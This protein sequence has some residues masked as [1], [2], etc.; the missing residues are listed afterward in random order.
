MAARAGASKATIYRRW[1]SKEELAVELVRELGTRLAVVADLGDAR[2]ELISVAADVIWRPTESDFGPV[3]RRLLCEIAGNPCRVNHSAPE[4]ARRPFTKY[5]TG[6]FI[7]GSTRSTARRRRREMDAVATARLSLGRQSWNFARHFLEMCVSMCA[8]GAILSLIVSGIPAL[9]GAPDLRERFPELGLILI[10]ILLTLPMAAWMRFRG[11]EW[12]P[13]VEMSAVPIGLAFL[14][15]GAV[16]AGLTPDS[17][18]QVTFGSFCGIACVGM[19]VV[20]L[21]RL[22]LYTGRSGHHMAHGEHAAH[23]A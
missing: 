18:L 10:A 12:R 4:G 15:I 14:L 9:L 19:F 21:P 16:W 17:T 2:Q 6:R 3:M 23:A 11:M 1:R 8:G 5:D 22:D 7:V 20:M 13:I